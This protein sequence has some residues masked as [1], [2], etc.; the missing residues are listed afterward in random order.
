MFDRPLTATLSRAVVTVLT[1]AAAGLLGVGGE[2][3]A[4]DAAQ[5]SVIGFSPD[6]A[7]FAFE[8]YGI[9]DG[10]GFPYSDVFV[11]ETATD[12]WVRGTPA[13][14]LVRNAAVSVDQ[15]RQ[16]ARKRIDPYLWRL[17]I[18]VNGQTLVS[19]RAADAR[20]AARFLPFTLKDDGEKLG[21]GTVRLRLTEIAMPKKDCAPL[22]VST[23]GYALVLENE[24]GEPLRILHE[25]TSIPGSRGC[26]V[27]YGLSDI[28]VYPRP[29]EGPVLVVLL[30]I[31][32]FGF[33][34]LDRRFLALSTAFDTN[35]SAQ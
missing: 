6:G 20:D 7:Y 5:R 14:E 23:H 24:A 32:Q 10:S 15:V 34:G 33:E 3:R 8:Q 16:T 35:P 31:Y 9:Q 30:S 13:R 4:A 22:G 12:S 19:D 25:D 2:A 11:L 28:I 1:I 17:N 18:G 29:G 26:P 21:L 27:H